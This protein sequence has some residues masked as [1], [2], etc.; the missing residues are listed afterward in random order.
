M[1]EKRGRREPTTRVSKPF[2]RKTGEPEWQKARH[3][4]CSSTDWGHDQRKKK[5]SQKGNGLPPVNEKGPKGGGA[6]G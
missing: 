6:N 5:P 3:E 1:F 4:T 2:N